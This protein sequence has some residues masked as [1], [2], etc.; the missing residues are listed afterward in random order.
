MAIGLRDK[1]GNLISGDFWANKYPSKHKS[2]WKP[3]VADM[4]QDIKRRKG[5]F[6]GKAKGNPQ[7]KLPSASL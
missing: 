6:G 7:I 4:L 2:K 1:Y 3:L 5:L